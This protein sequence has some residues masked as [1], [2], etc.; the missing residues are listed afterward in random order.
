MDPPSV[1]KR[2]SDALNAA[3]MTA[4]SSLYADKIKY[5]GVSFDRAA[6][7]EKVSKILARKPY[8]Q[9]IKDV[10]HWRVKNGIRVQFH[11]LYGSKTEAGGYLVLDDATHLIIEESDMTTDDT[12]LLAGKCTPYFVVTTITG[13]L[14]HAQGPPNDDFWVIALDKRVCL[15]NEDGGDRAVCELPEATGNLVGTLPESKPFSLTGTF[16]PPLRHQPCSFDITSARAIT[17]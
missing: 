13:D 14:S 15:M 7:V 6:L 3:D 16:G 8:H 4:L 2:W 11:K 12:L 5:Y 1:A 17:K 9:E 10:A